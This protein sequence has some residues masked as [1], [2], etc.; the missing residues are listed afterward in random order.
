MKRKKSTGEGREDGKR[1]ERAVRLH[2]EEIEEKEEIERHRI[3]MCLMEREKERKRRK[4][5]GREAT[6]GKERGGK[7]SVTKAYKWR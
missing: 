2:E 7:R 3:H 1:K 4:R 6:I 5:E